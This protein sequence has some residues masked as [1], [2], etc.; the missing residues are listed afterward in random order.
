MA[1]AFAQAA[2][3]LEPTVRLA[4]AGTDAVPNLAARF[5]IRSIPT[6][7]LFIGGREVARQSLQRDNKT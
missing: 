1:P 2:T 5:D 3:V 6:L 7:A 4:N